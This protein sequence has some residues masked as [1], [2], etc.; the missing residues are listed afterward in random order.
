MSVAYCSVN[1]TLLAAQIYEKMGQVHVAY[2]SVKETLLA[3]QLYEKM[4]QVC[5][6]L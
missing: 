3:A 6:L 2:C 5:S 1:E 4:G